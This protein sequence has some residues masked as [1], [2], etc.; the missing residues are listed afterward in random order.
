MDVFWAE[1]EFLYKNKKSMQVS[2][3]VFVFVKAIDVK[4]ALEKIRN[5]FLKSNKKPVF[6]N[7]IKPYNEL[8]SNEKDDLKYSKMCTIASQTDSCVFDTFYDY[9]DTKYIGLVL[10]LSI[11]Y[12]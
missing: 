8:W 10:K 11:I 5:D 9:K 2:G 7:F 1:V 12:I 6:F 3:M 4:S